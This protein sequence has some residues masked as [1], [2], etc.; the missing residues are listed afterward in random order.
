[1][2]LLLVLIVLLLILLGEPLFVIL[3]MIA[4]CCFYFFMPD[5]Y[6]DLDSFNIFIEKMFELTDKNVLLAI[7]FFVVSGTIMTAGKIAQRL[8]DFA[9]A[10]TGWLPGGLAIST[11]LACMFFAAISGSSPV[12]II[13]IGSMMFPAL[14]KDSYK[15]NFSLGL[16]TSAG[17]LGILIPPSI[18]MLIYA[19]MVSGTV[20][21]DVGELFLA[22][23][24]PGFVIGSFLAVYSFIE[25]K[26]RKTSVKKFRFHEVRET[27]RDGFWAL[28]LP[29]VVLGGIYVGVF[30]PTEAAA[31]SVVYAL[32]VEIFIHRQITL[33][34]VP[35]L[36]AEATLLMGSLLVIMVMAFCFNEFLV[37]NQVAQRA[38]EWMAAKNFTPVVFLVVMNVLLLIVGFFMDIMSAI[39]ILSPLLAPT[40]VALGLHPVHVAIIT[41]VNLEIGYLT[42]PMGL[43]LFVSTSLFKKSFGQV[44]RSVIPFTGVMLIGLIIVTY[45]PTVSIGPVNY[46]AGRGFL[47]PLV[48]EEEAPETEA[49]EEGEAAPGAAEQEGAGKKEKVQSIMEMM[50]ELEAMEDEA[51]ADESDAEEESL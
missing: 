14:V 11:V 44:V 33:K 35:A 4:T 34:D 5:I 2:I 22:G 50:Q 28:L 1:M 19:I 21:I 37:Q 32:V 25:G 24:L 27:F 36:F 26:R 23:V 31:V 12:T 39:M 48:Q 6:H 40:A 20:V 41:I 17:S 15:E 9:R 18:P 38:V 7:P 16:V 43:N 29:V 30:T 13:A 51:D 46:L 47:T 49:Q 10:V 3:G 8:I 45:V 42:P